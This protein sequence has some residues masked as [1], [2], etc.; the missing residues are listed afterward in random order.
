MDAIQSGIGLIDSNRRD[1][2]FWK[3]DDSMYG[4]LQSSFGTR[5]TNGAVIVL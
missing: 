1:L 5:R 3:I 2:F 4:R